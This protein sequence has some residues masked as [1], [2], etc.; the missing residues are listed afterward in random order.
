MQFLNIPTK[1]LCSLAVSLS[2]LSSARCYWWL[3][4]CHSQGV[5]WHV[6]NPS[7]LDCCIDATT[8]PTFG[9]ILHIT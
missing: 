6:P 8:E 5:S 9:N 2:S 3:I 7:F 1:A 4:A